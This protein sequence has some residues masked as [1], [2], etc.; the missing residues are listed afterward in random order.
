M[1]NKNKFFLLFIIVILQNVLL[2]L[3]TDVEQA[4]A[5][6]PGTKRAR[7]RSPVRTSFLVRL[8]R[9]FSS[10]VRQMSE[11][12]RHSWFSEYY[13]AI[14]IIVIISAFLECMSE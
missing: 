5:C 6:A 4:V 2:Q 14:I 12:F 10:P 13:L 9:G 8:F 3:S 11:S 1:Y 7:V